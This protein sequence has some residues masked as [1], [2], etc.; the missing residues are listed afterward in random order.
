MESL[1]N[2]VRLCM[3]NRVDYFFVVGSF[4]TQN[5]THKIINT[6]KKLASIPVIL[7]PGSSM[8]IDLQ[9]DGILFL[10]LISGRNPEF[11]IGQQVLAAPILKNSKI[12]VMSTGYILVGDTNHTTVSYISNTTPIPT[13]KD[14]IAAC[15]ALAGEML[16][17][18]LIYLD[19]GSGAQ[20]PIPG[21]MI[22]KVRNMVEAPLIVGGG[23]NSIE[24]VSTAL[25][26]GADTIV[27]GNG[28][29]DNQDLLVEI[30]DFL[31]QNNSLKIH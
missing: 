15:T 24:K 18:R 3:E 13:S 8:H 21:K 7:F 30:A 25:K 23:L 9:A 22:K 1:T 19:A 27:V 12:E 16:G 5:Y 17:M 26:S 6:I 2:L 28:I 14:S 20:T 4:V 10:S 29:E 31:Q 11:L